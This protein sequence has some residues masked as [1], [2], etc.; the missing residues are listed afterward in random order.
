M[1][2]TEKK[3]GNISLPLILLIVSL[4]ILLILILTV[5]NKENDSPFDESLYLKKE[6]LQPRTLT[7]REVPTEEDICVI[8][9][10]KIIECKILSSSGKYIFLKQ[11]TAMD[12]SVSEIEYI[13]TWSNISESNWELTD[14]LYRFKCH[15]NRGHADWGTDPCL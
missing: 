1:E 3:K 9:E 10:G 8:N 2:N 12:D 11:V 15:E 7:D 13:E 14:L 5:F 4:S 6:I